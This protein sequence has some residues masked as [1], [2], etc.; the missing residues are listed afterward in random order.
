MSLALKSGKGQ[1]PSWIK[2]DPYWNSAL[3]ILESLVKRD[4][5]FLALTQAHVNIEESTIS[6]TDMKREAALW[7]RGERLMIDLAAHLFNEEVHE[8]YLSDFELLDSQ[9]KEI[10]IKG[11]RKRFNI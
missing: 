4:S 1:I 9:L 8:F 5:K 11:I 6:F 10:A 7:P 2:S 3:Y